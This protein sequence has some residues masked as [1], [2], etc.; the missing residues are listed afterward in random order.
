MTHDEDRL[1]SRDQL[2]ETRRALLERW[3]QIKT[4]SAPA[5]ATPIPR[6]ADRT[7]TPL[8]FAQ[9][10]LWLVN[11]LDPNSAAYNMPGV[12]HLRGRL[13]VT[14]LERSLHQIVQRHDV[15]RASFVDVDG[16][17]MQRVEQEATVTLR[18]VDLRELPQPEQAVVVRRHT[19]DEARQPFDLAQGPLLRTLLLQLGPQEHLLLLTLHHIIADG[20][21]IGVFVRELAEIYTA[22]IDGRPA[23]LPALPVQYADFADWQRQ[24][25]QGTTHARQIDHWRQRLADLPTLHLPTDR[26]RPP[27]QTFQGDRHRLHVAANLT[28]ALK[29]LGQQH[30][31]TLFMTLLAAWQT[32]LQRYSQ[33]DEIVVGSVA[34]GRTRRELEALIGF[35]VDNLVLR[36]DLS[37]NPTFRELLARVRATCVDAYAHQDMPFVQLVEVLQPDRDPSRS[38]L[39]QVMFVLQPSQSD[40]IAL[41]DLTLTLEE[42]DTGTAKFDLMLNLE[43]HADGLRG[44]IEYNTALF[45]AATIARMAA[46]FQTLLTGIVADPDAP[47][48]HLPLLTEAEQQQM[49]VDWNRS[50]A[51]YPC[52]AAVHALI[53]VQA[54]RTP[55]VPAIVFDG[56]ALSYAEL[57]TRANQLAHYLR[58]QGV[59]PDVLVAL[60]VERSL[61]MIVG[62]LAILKAGGAYVPLDPTYPA[63]RLQYM[64]SHSRAPVLL[65]QAALVERLPEHQAQVFCL[66]ADW[67]RLAN[68]STTNPP[69]TALPE[70]LA[71]IIFTS[72]STG[73]PKGVMVTQRGLINLVYGLRAY[74]TDPAVQHTGLITSISFDISVNQIFPTLIFGRTLHI[75][76]DPVKFN[77]RALLRYLDEHQIHLLDAV[78]SYLHAVLNTPER[79]PNVLRYLLLG[80]EKIEPRLLQ[81]VFGQLGAQVE[82]VNI[83]GLT[84]ISDIN[85]LGVI[86]AADR[87]KPITV[88][89]PLQNNRIYIL[90]RFDQ[91]QPVGIAGEV[92]IS[93]E[94]V[95]RGYL[96]RPE[97]TAE[98]FVPCPFEDGQIMVRTGDLG[99]WQPDGTVEIL[100][101]IDH[102]V[103]IRGFRIETGEIEAV[104]AQHPQVDE[105]VVLAREDG[106]GAL[107]ARRLVAYVV[108]QRTGAIRV[109]CPE[110]ARHGHS[111]G[112]G[113]QEPRAGNSKLET[114]NLKLETWK[115]E[116][117]AYLKEHLPEYMIPS[118][119]VFLEALPKTPSG[120]IDRRALPAPERQAELTA[121]YVAPRTE[122]EL[123]LAG[124]WA[125]V[126]GVERVSAHDNFF[127][128]GGHSLLATQIASRVRDAFQVELPLRTLFASPTVGSLAEWIDQAGRDRVGLL[129]PPLYRAPRDRDLPLSFAQQR[130][131]FLSQLQPDSA[132]YVIPAAV[133]LTGLLDVAALETSLNA[134]V[135]RHETLRTTFEA[136]A[137]QPIQ[138]IAPSYR[139]TLAL[140]DLS[141][142]P[143][144]ARTDEVRRRLAQAVRQPFDLAAGPLLRALLLRLDEDEHLLLLTMHHIIADG[145]SIGVLLRE[146]A[147]HYNAPD[148]LVPDLPIQYADYALWQRD[149]LAGCPQGIAPGELLERQLAYWRQQ[150]AAAPSVLKL[151]TDR[152]R[153]PTMTFEGTLMP[154]S[155]PPALSNRLRRLSQQEGVTLFMTLLAAWQTL[156]GHYSG[157]RDLIVGSPIANRRH[158]ATEDLIGF[159]VNTLVLRADL[160]GNPTFRALLRRTRATTLGAYAHQD[161]PF[162]Q[163]VEHLRPARDPSYTPLFQVMFVLQNTP[164]PDVALAGL[165][166]Q[167]IDVELGM[168]KYDLILALDDRAEELT[169]WIEYRTDLFDAA[170]IARMIEHFRVLLEA[171]AVDPEQRLV[172]LPLLTEAERQ[173]ML[174]E[175]NATDAP[176]ADEACVHTCFEAQAALTPDAVALT[177]NGQSLT[178]DALNRRANQLAHDLRAR[179]VARGMRVGLCVDRGLELIVGFL[180]ILKAGGVYVPLDPGY[181]QERLAFM[182]ADTQA[183][184]LLTQQRLAERLADQHVPLVYLDADWPLI[185][186]EPETNPG[187]PI[188]PDDLAYI[189]YTSGS[190]GRPKGVMLPHRGLV[191]LTASQIRRMNVGVGSRVLQFA[192]PS[193]DA[194]VWEFVF[195]LL[196]GAALCI[197]DREALLPGLA[198]YTL[199]REQAITHALV[200]PSALALTRADD[201]PQLAVIN[202]G[203]EACSAEVVARWLTDADGRRRRFF[204]SYG[205]TE[206]T[207]YSTSFECRDA[208]PHSPPIGRPV[209]NAQVYILNAGLHPVPVGVVGELYIGGVGLAHGYLNRPDL[210]AERFIPDPF[211]QNPGAR[212]YK[213]GDL[214][215]YQPDGN[216]IY[217]GRSDQQVKVRGF[218][219]E[220]GEIETVLRQHPAIRE[221]VVLAREDHPGDTR[222]VA[223]VVGEQGNKGTKEQTGEQ[224]RGCP[225]GMG[226]PNKEQRNQETETRN[227]ELGTWNSELRT[228]VRQRLPDYMVPNTFVVLDTL[229]LTPNGKLDRSALPVPDTARPALEAAFVAPRTEVER[230]IAAVWQALLNIEQI[231]LHDNFFDLGGHSLL[232]VQAH[233]QLS[234]IFNCAIAMV[235]LFKYPTVSALA[236]HLSQ[237]TPDQSPPQSK[238]QLQT[239]K[240]GRSWLKQRAGRP[241]RGEHQE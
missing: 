111:H 41:P 79:P 228:Y 86:R 187:A 84:E 191:S 19:S 21:S 101:R 201:L 189:I 149:W 108:E 16:V 178:Y 66:D 123:I 207:V 186:H 152:P 10:R 34:A 102:Q 31:A 194:S 33:Q 105:C 209:G 25:M 14:V 217:L 51:E 237:P 93:G 89:K 109:P 164:L 98:R 74:F 128:L 236:E 28:Q 91:P 106:A 85:A 190:T 214:A 171:I 11:Q 154:L 134:V 75:I 100:G 158:S 32:L 131:W 238:Q 168:V 127:E 170:T 77:S 122:T 78:P 169:G 87:G 156:L 144:D 50:G 204:N 69:R 22:L 135:Q 67:D 177:Y 172:D 92:C 58:A 39:F 64:L 26:P 110:G 18:R 114:R 205:P 153:P 42:G 45:E 40:T 68:C 125:E 27:L 211:G 202:A 53:E 219:I 183:P 116:L 60:C 216:V 35:F 224:R 142:L 146:I 112:T 145:W 71:Y 6:L 48:A 173:R 36:T 15:L 185:A 129:P 163:L 210:T 147:A 5:T 9:Q 59:G 199:L 162:E 126:L 143:P 161:L 157:Q 233:S 55:D 76:P 13:D 138:R 83:Y 104:L 107:G 200:S 72:G 97:L 17:P 231:G 220:L 29:E 95:S 96:F 1:P 180:A 81:A 113:N 3:L 213:T 166:L 174:Y 54:A 184:L 103:K 7:C 117:R 119:F 62:M 182:L 203:T 195:A 225:L 140:H 49:L 4:R 65:T 52:A 80:G 198:I 155:L 44:W 226:T 167:R 61:E 120:K 235:D 63:E 23:S 47:I 130:L 90:N 38:P 196:S 12:V 24:R 139:L 193:F 175:W 73:R 46:H 239:V 20:W 8:S 221:A 43:E 70:H 234:T 37:G 132:T 212:L 218:R 99:R 137:G 160:S 176:Y 57:N 150:L 208:P 141:A 151:P 159:F 56:Q 188:T 241:R 223:Y 165:E 197:A 222:L 179:G 88:G 192:S 230:T 2:S 118:A 82:V 229:P 94:S 232:V 30:S 124:L 136:V 215:R 181:P 148:P 206:T 121:G 133:R 227:L 115:S 240:E